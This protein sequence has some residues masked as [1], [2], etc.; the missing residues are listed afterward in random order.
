MQELIFTLNK[1]DKSSLGNIRCIPE[2]KVAED[3]NTFWIRGV[4]DDVA[5]DKDIRQLPLQHSYYLDEG[6]LLFVL[7][8][9]TPVGVLPELQW[10]PVA[11]FIPIKMP[12]AA[13]PGQLQQPAITRLVS[14]VD[15]KTGNALLTT[16]KQWKAYAETAPGIRLAQLKFAVSQN[17][18]VLIMGTPIPPIPGKEYWTR[19]N[20]LLPC[21]CDLEIPMAAT[22]INEQLNPVQ[23]GFLIF[24]MDGNCE[25]IDLAFLVDAKRSAVR[26]TQLMNDEPVN[27]PES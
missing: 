13:L 27:E 11:D 17:N 6:N 26:L 7:G 21:G 20:I 2:L 4:Y 18:Q 25:K 10:L 24:D 14:S 1:K 3:D 15:H 5:T 23:D 12:V 19:N 22:F 9:L 16:L 8:G